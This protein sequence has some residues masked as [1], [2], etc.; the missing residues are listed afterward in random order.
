MPPDTG[1][2]DVEADDGDNAD[3]AGTEKASCDVLCHAAVPGWKCWLVL[4][5]ADRW[6]FKLFCVAWCLA[7]APRPAPYARAGR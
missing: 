3:V 1:P 4:A 2:A 6:S 7:P 5:G